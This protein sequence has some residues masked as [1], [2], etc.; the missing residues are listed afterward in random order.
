MV[1]SILPSAAGH[2]L[3]FPSLFTRPVLPV[4]PPREATKRALIIAINYENLPNQYQLKG[5]QK[6]AGEFRD[7]LEH[8][9]NY[10]PESITVLT[11]EAGTPSERFA[12]KSNI[13]S[14]ALVPA[15]DTC[16]T[17]N[18]SPA[19]LQIKALK[20]FYDEQMAGNEYL[21]Y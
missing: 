9:Y 16:I 21:I 13:V 8:Y 2:R 4:Q 11:D 6:E 19:A 17:N 14:P 1:R 10:L 15:H 5:P 12:S 20:I 18:S 3:L 7:L